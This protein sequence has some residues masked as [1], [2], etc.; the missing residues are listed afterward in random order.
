M[1]IEKPTEK[2][3]I[4]HGSGV[5]F[6]ARVRRPDDK[7][8]KAAAPSHLP[9]TGGFSESKV[10]GPG[11]EEYFYKHV[12]TFKRAHSRSHGDF[13]DPR[14][15]LEFT[16]GNHGQN[17]LPANTAAEASLEGLRIEF[18]ADHEEK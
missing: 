4:F 13:S 11:I 9:V 3:V 12:L 7:F 8:I 6:A 16:H 2:R 18:E 15:A 5:A 17:N 1:P 14:A 10:E